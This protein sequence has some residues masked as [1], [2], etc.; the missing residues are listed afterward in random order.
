LSFVGGVPLLFFGSI[1]DSDGPLA[2]GMDVDMPDFDRPLVTSPMPVKRLD[3][4]EMEPQ[5]LGGKTAVNGDV[6]L[7]HVMLALTQEFKPRKAGRHNLNGKQGLKLG[8]RFFGCDQGD[9]S[10]KGGL[11]QFVCSPSEPT[12]QIELIA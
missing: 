10:I 7:I 5:K 11:I 3:H 4:I 8:L 9:R 12:G 2:A 6:G 1:E